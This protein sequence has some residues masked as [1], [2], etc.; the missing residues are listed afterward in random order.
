M[1]RPKGRHHGDWH[2]RKE[3]AHRQWSDHTGVDQGPANGTRHR[4]RGGAV[5]YRPAP[6]GGFFKYV[7][8]RAVG[9]VQEIGA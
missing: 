4:T 3:K 8:K 7:G 5:R 9:R 6:G 1:K 2:P